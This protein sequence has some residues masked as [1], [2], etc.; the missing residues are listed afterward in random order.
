MNEEKANNTDAEKAQD[1][2]SEAEAASLEAEVAAAQ[3]ELDAARAKLAEIKAREEARVANAEK[4]DYYWQQP[5]PPEQSQGAQYA[6]PQTPP[7]YQAPYQTTAYAKSNV[8]AGLL[9]I[10]LGSLGI[11]K[12]YLGYTTA[13]FIMLAITIVGSIFTLGLAGG[14]VAIIGI[15]EG[16][17]Y[18]TKT[19][20]EF[21]YTYIQNSR[22]WF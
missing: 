4:S 6:P 21:Q 3:A 1:I 5:P 19:P 12:F 8:A 14:V 7:N 11:H 13:G 10:F 16:I 20:Q 15:V 2:T 17:M 9:A 22:E 18:L